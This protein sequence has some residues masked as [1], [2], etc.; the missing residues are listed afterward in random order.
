MIPADVRFLTTKDTFVAQAAL[1]G[2]S[3][4]VEKFSVS[5]SADVSLTDLKNI[6]FMGSNIVSGSATAIALATGN[7]TYFGAMAKS[8][9]GDRAKNSFERGVDSVSGL[10]IRLMLVIIPVVLLINGVTKHDWA[11]AVLFAISIAVG[12]TPEM[13]PVI[14]TST[15]A[16]GAVSMSKRNVIVKTLGAIQT[17]GEMN[18]LCTDK[19][20]T[21]TEDK[22][23]L[24]KYMNLSGEDDSRILRHAYR[25]SYFQTGL[26]N[27]IDL[28]IINR[29]VSNGLEETLADF[30]RVDEIPFDFTRR[31]MSVVLEG[32]D[33]KRQL[34]TKGA[35]E[36]LIAISSS[37]LFNSRATF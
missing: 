29:A 25:N 4:P 7:D 11:G 23:V 10:L 26:K 17:F 37:I 27:L 1:T 33:G 3:N 14:M 35:V 9:S 16:K 31:R 19:T 36:E 13:L 28:A 20:G 32:K 15:L 21:L 30:T 8:L 34:I 24:E 2:E 6:G 18:I 12:L 22:I 5:K